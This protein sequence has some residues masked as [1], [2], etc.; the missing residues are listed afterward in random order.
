MKELTRALAAKAGL[1]Q[2]QTQELLNQFLDGITERLVHQG[3]MRLGDFG[4]FSVKLRRARHGRNP[5]TGER[6]EIP[7][8]VV[9]AF[10]PGTEL[11]AKIGQLKGVPGQ[12]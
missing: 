10:K 7:G 9:V 6:I 11:R 4:V 1:T 12:G 3:R 5:R 8:R 2:K